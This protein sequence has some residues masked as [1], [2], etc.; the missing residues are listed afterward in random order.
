MKTGVHI[1]NFSRGELVHE[2]DIADALE[3]GKVGK[4]ITDFPNKIVLKMKNAICIPHLGG[5]TRESEENCAIM[6]AR[7]VEEF[8]ET[9]NI[10]NSVNFPNA[11]LPYSGKPRVTAYHRNI[12]I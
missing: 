8:L 7:Q 10:K 2:K 6:A 3:E 11:Y 12:R 4:Y 1:L 9:G 5:S